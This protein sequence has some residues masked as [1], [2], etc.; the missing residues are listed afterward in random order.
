M[1]ILSKVIY[2]YSADSIKTPTQFFTEIKKKKI[3]N[4]I[5]KF[6]IPR[7]TETVL[8]NKMLVVV[9]TSDFKV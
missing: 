2:Q 1:A 3:L 8:N 4:P 9:N 7:K 6:Q 5:W